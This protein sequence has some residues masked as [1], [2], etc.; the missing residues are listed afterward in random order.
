MQNSADDVFVVRA[1]RTAI[2]NPEMVFGDGHDA[3]NLAS[4]APTSMIFVSVTAA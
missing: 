3:C 1:A 4:V 2:C